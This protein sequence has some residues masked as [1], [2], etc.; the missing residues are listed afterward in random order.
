MSKM[1]RTKEKFKEILE[2]MNDAIATLET[3]CA[4]LEAAEGHTGME[5]DKGPDLWYILRTARRA[6]DE[7]ERVQNDFHEW[8]G[9][10]DPPRKRRAK[11]AAGQPS[12]RVVEPA[13]A[14][15]PKGAA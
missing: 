7:L 9:G 11:P 15:A 5:R 1:P 8:N 3:V 4:A 12:L 13:P 14:S 6:T 2:C 10:Y